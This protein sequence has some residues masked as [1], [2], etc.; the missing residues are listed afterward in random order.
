VDD[1]IPIA[2]AAAKLT[3]DVRIRLAESHGP[4]TIPTLKSILSRHRGGIPVCVIVP[5]NGAGRVTIKL[6]RQDWGVRPEKAL[7]DELTSA[8]G[9]DRVSLIGEGSRRNPPKQKPL[10]ESE[11]VEAES[12]PASSAPVA[13]MEMVED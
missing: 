4:Q 2:D 5:A 12:A 3:T 11:P 10:F 1:L 9:A 8:I 6:D 13:E 7:I